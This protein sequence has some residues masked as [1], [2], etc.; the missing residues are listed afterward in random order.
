MSERRGWAL[1]AVVQEA[2]I[3]G[4]SAHPWSRLW[5]RIS[6]SQVS[7]LCGEMDERVRSIPNW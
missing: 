6:K 2:W 4:V 1:A 3:G 7:K 5:A